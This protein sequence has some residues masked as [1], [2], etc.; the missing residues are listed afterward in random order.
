MNPIAY[1]RVAEILAGLALIA[2][3]CWGVHEFL[4]HERDIGRKE[5]QVE[6]DKQKASDKLASEHQEKDWQARLDAAI[7]KG[8][9]DEQARQREAAATRA[10]ADSLRNT[11]TTLQQ[12]LPTASAEAARK[13]AAT[14]ANIFNDC[15]ARYREMGEA[16]Q[17][18]A[19]DTKTLDTAWPK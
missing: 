4:E 12:L 5:K 13:Y 15:V 11:N 16:A 3:I 19:N 1:L 9:V 14:Y 6:W 2:G 18:H 7:A 8:S 10:A 17:G